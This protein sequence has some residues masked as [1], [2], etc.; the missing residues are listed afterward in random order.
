[1][2]MSD[3]KS[4]RSAPVLYLSRCGSINGMQR[5]LLYL[6]TA[7]DRTRHPVTSVVNEPGELHD[8]L[9]KQGIDAFIRPMRNWRSFPKGLLRYADAFRLTG[10]ARARGIRLVHAHDVWRAEYAR[11]VARRL[12]IPYIVHVRGPMSRRDILKHN[13]HLADGLIAISDRYVHDLVAAGVSQDRIAMIDDAVDASAFHPGLADAGYFRRRY[14]LEGRLFVGLVGRVSEFKGI[15]EFLEIVAALRLP[16]ENQIRFVVIGDAFDDGYHHKVRLAMKRLALEERVRFIG[17]CSSRE[18]PELLASLDVLVTL[19]GGSIMFEAMACGKPV[20]TVRKD[21]RHSRHELHGNTVLCVSSDNPG[22]SAAALARL[23]EDELLRRQLGDAA[24]NWVRTH[25]QVEMMAEKTVSFYQKFLRMP[26]DL[27]VTD[28]CQN[29]ENHFAHPNI[30]VDRGPS[31]QLTLNYIPDGFRHTDITHRV[32][33]DR[34]FRLENEGDCFV[35]RVNDFDFSNRFH[36]NHIHLQKQKYYVRPGEIIPLIL[37]YRRSIMEIASTRAAYSLKAGD[38]A[39]LLGGD[40]Y[41]GS[42]QCVL[43]TYGYPVSVEILGG[44]INPA[45]GKNYNIADFRLPSPEAPSLHRPFV[46][47]VLGVR[48]DCGKS[49]TIRQIA[50]QLRGKGYSV[51]TGKVSG[52]GCLYET[53]NLNSDLSIDFTDFGLPS[54]CGHLEEKVLETAKQILEH[55]K[56]QH[57]DVIILEFGGDLIGPY[58]VTEVMQKLRDQI[59]YTIFVTFDLCGLKGGKEHLAGI[60][61]RIDLVS[62]PLV[63]TSLGVEMVNQWFQLPAESNQAEMT[64]TLATMENLMEISRSSSEASNKCRL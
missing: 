53:A 28:F 60:N 4:V 32:Y 21:G 2:L 10:L 39:Y 45:T 31:V 40:G 56:H 14:N 27:P 59:D 41:A 52:F 26:S 35:G 57:S 58:R 63:N 51:V 13:L 62:G 25:L 17:R 43:A 12:G 55:L 15:I 9:R 16:A 22:D 48:M 36:L 33:C 50:G 5:Q 37:A 7:T 23:L 3:Y 8:E 20:L 18:M 46:I 44:I 19:S 42:Y 38:S 54:T 47:A 61:C 24:L 1:M 49:T 29:D 6:A 64:G 11:F 30:T 34:Q